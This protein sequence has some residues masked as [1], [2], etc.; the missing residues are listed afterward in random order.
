ML[1]K[2]GQHLGQF[3]WFVSYSQFISK[4]ITR[5][6]YRN[7]VFLFFLDELCDRYQWNLP[8][9]VKLW[10]WP[11]KPFKRQPHKI[12]KYTQTIHWLLP[13]NC[14]KVFDHFLGLRLKGLKKKWALVISR[15]KQTSIRDFFSWNIWNFGVDLFLDSASFYIYILHI[16][17]ERSN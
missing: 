4:V 1:Q 2:L 6:S 10:N 5:N 11:F 17:I 16:S 12:I 3:E 13:T 7:I 9:K 15:K 14:L 8:I